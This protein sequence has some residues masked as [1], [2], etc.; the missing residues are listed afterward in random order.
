[1]SIHRLTLIMK[2]KI[3]I[4]KGESNSE[5]DDSSIQSLNNREKNKG[6]ND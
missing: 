4:S 1:M 2:G 3:I 5:N 6:G